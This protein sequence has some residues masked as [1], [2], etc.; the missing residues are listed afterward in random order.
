MYMVYLLT[1]IISIK[2]LTIHGSVNIPYY[3]TLSVWVC[4]QSL[5]LN[6][7]QITLDPTKKVP[8]ERFVNTGSFN[9]ETEKAL[10]EGVR[11]FFLGRAGF[12]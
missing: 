5:F 1:F 10:S 2:T 8:G 6:D 12:I 11:V 9:S 4:L 3:D 7:F